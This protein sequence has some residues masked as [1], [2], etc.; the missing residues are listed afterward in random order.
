MN[1]GSATHWPS[2]EETLK[3]IKQY[4]AVSVSL[5]IY[6][7]GKVSYKLIFLFSKKLSLWFIWVKKVPLMKTI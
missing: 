5:S 6:I 1:F 2:Q 4:W 3:K 7:G